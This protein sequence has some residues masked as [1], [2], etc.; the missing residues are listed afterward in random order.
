MENKLKTSQFLTLEEREKATSIQIHYRYF[1]ENF[2]LCCRFLALLCKVDPEMQSKSFLV[3]YKHIFMISCYLKHGKA[4]HM[5]PANLTLLDQAASTLRA[6]AA[7]EPIKLRQMKSERVTAAILL[8]AFSLINI[9]ACTERR[10]DQA[11][12]LVITNLLSTF[13]EQANCLCNSLSI[14]SDFADVLNQV[15]K[16]RNSKAA[17]KHRF[18][19]PSN[20]INMAERARFT[21][22]AIYS[23]II[24]AVALLVGELYIR[25]MNFDFE[26]F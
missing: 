23:L 16:F 2:D 8:I 10:V 3:F 1:D 11:Q 21:W 4:S 18:Q 6:I 17:T 14:Y 24:F 13:S 22:F 19:V 12:S 26:N 7:S 9:H 5:K 15:Y 25:N 20:L